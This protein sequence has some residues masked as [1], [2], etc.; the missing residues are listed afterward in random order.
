MV[1]SSIGQTLQLSP[2]GTLDMESSL[3]SNA[4]DSITLEKEDSTMHL[5]MGKEA[6]TNHYNNLQPSLQ[7]VE[8][9]DDEEEPHFFQRENALIF[10]L[11][12]IVQHPPDGPFQRADPGTGGARHGNGGKRFAYRWR[13]GV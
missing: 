13:S 8:V 5:Q 7:T 6:L 1:R 3:L 10:V 4:M 12:A 9:S 2:Y 11:A